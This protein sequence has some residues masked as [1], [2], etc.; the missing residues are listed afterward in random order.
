MRQSTIQLKQKHQQPLKADA[1]LIERLTHKLEQ[2]IAATTGTKLINYIRA[3]LKTAQD[4]HDSNPKTLTQPEQPAASPRSRSPTLPKKNH[5][6]SY[7]Q[8][9]VNEKI[10]KSQTPQDKMH[11]M[12]TLAKERDHTRTA[13]VANAKKKQMKLTTPKVH[14]LS[15]VTNLEFVEPTKTNDEWTPVTKSKKKVPTS[16]ESFKESSVELKHLQPIV[17]MKI[18]VLLQNHQ[19]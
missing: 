7:A 1:N 2:L 17:M 11:Q 16:K 4:E 8:K 9:R 19:N 12:R 14:N 5:S 18:Q 3:E 6:Q 10:L 15:K 13:K